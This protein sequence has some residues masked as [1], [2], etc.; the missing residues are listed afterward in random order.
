MSLDCFVTYVLDRSVEAQWLEVA[1]AALLLEAART[2]RPSPKGGPARHFQYVYPLLGTFLLTGG[3]E[4][5]ILGLEVADVSFGRETVTFRVNEHRRLKTRKSHRVVPLWPQLAEILRPYTDR[6]VIDRGGTL[7]FPS[8]TG[9]MLK[10]WR[11][12]LDAVAKRAGWTA[13]Q[14]RSKQ[15]RHTYCAARLQTLD[16]GAP[17]S[18]FTVARELGHNSTDMVEQVYSHLGTVR[19]RSEQVEYR[20][21]QHEKALGDRLTALRTPAM[22]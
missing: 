3:R 22:A 14:I 18:V 17:V 11:K 13:G 9:G 10:D 5:E 1:D 21:E 20:V 15:F 4:A 2:I 19:H 7:L 12:V 6:R 8:E 16:R